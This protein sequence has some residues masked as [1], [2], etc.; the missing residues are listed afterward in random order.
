[1][2]QE[3]AGG[4]G[5]NSLACVAVV[6]VRKGWLEAQC[7]GQNQEDQAPEIVAFNTRPDHEPNRIA[8]AW[9]VRKRGGRER[10]LRAGEP[11][12]ITR[13]ERVRQGPGLA[14]RLGG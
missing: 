12:A 6:Q 1:M 10:A 11:S 2:S 13:D 5:E 3:G 7:L 8:E 4:A 9:E 14:G